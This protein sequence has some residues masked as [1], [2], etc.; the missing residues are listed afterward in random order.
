MAGDLD[1]ADEEGEDEEDW[2]FPNEYPSQSFKA[3]GALTDNEQE[4]LL[5][6]ASTNKVEHRV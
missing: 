6:V 4:S 5:K 3:L 2:D 1:I